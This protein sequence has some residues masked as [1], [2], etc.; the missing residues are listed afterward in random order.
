MNQAGSEVPLVSDSSSTSNIKSTNTSTSKGSSGSNSLAYAWCVE[1][2]GVNVGY[3]RKLVLEIFSFRMPRGSSWA[4]V[5]PSGVGKTTLF[6][7]IV[8]LLHPIKGQIRV[9]GESCPSSGGWKHLKGRIGYI[10]QNL[11][12][13]KALDVR[14]NILLGA[15]G[16]TPSLLSLFGMFHSS[17]YER[18]DEL[19]SRL[20]I[21]D[22]AT[23]RVQRLSGGQ[24][25]RVA[26]ARAL[27]QGPDLL[28]ADEF[29][30][31]LDSRTTEKV[32]AVVQEFRRS[33]GMSL[34]LIE[35][36]FETAQAYA[37][38]LVILREGRLESIVEGIG[39]Q[40]TMA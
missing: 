29:L 15:L 10:P 6:K 26:I 32:M 12:L 30:S 9:L 16:R 39:Q 5:G 23:S 27:L 14:T 22:I 33:R 7:V 25:R 24:K 11:G 36:N 13:V 28:I 2:K 40:S 3:N 37:E 8:G 18:A 4:I 1:L 38:K 34:L 35:H 20:D 21:R 31:E 17:E 19:M